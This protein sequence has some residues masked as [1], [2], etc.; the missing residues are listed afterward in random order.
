[1]NRICTRGLPALLFFVTSVRAHTETGAQ[2]RLRYSPITNANQYS[3][4]PN[5]IV[6]LGNTPTDQAASTELQRGLTSMLGRSFT[7]SHVT[8]D[9]TSAIILTSL[10]TLSKAFT[11]T[12]DELP[13]ESYALGEK[14]KVTPTVT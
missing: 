12:G 13:P 8:P 14:K 2:G 1:M 7:I 9:N 4:L 5:K 10:S 11:L 3:T 6:V